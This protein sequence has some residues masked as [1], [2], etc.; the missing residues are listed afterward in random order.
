M[1]PRRSSAEDRQISNTPPLHLSNFEVL[2]HFLALKKETDELHQLITQRKARKDLAARE[3]YPA[4]EKDEL[5]DL[6][7]VPPLDRGGVMEKN[8]DIAERRGESRE[9]VWIQDRVGL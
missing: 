8:E 4:R 5:E 6:P 3:L 2:T 7:Y 1:T 9:L